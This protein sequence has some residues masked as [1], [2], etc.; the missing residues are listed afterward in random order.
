M[1]Q[2]QT[3]VGQIQ[4]GVG[5][6]Q[7]GAGQTQTGVGQTQAGVGQTQTGVEQTQALWKLALIIKVIEIVFWLTA[8]PL[9]DF[10]QSPK[11]LIY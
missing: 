5:Q 3:G 1:G 7:T 6:T 4:T 2:T 9:H 10:Q 8:S 11:S